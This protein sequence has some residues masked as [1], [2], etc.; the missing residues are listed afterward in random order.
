MSVT[1]LSRLA[2]VCLCSVVA[3]V[4]ALAGPA[5]TPG[6]IPKDSVGALAAR[7]EDAKNTYA[8]DATVVQA[9]LPPS[10]SNPVT[11]TKKFEIDTSA[12]K[13]CAV[14]AAEVPIDLVKPPIR[15]NAEFK[16]DQTVTISGLT[17]SLRESTDEEE[18][19]GVRVAFEL[20]DISL[21]TI[22][23]ADLSAE[24]FGLDRNFTIKLKNLSGY[25]SFSPPKTGQRGFK[26]TSAKFSIGDVAV[27]NDAEILKEFISKTV[28]AAL[29]EASTRSSIEAGL[30]SSLG[31]AAGPAV[32]ALLDLAFKLKLDF[33][34]GDE[35]KSIEFQ[36]TKRNPKCAASPCALYTFTN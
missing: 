23:K 14:N 3:A 19:F 8:F 24:C 13:K 12:G 21:T 15:F 26:F 11:L 9:I 32:A 35:I 33:A 2:A 29:S 4:P 28:D 34:A 36:A 20:S 18:P 10:Y 22:R 17:A 1:S 7:L 25:L 27:S 16:I 6:A 31:A 30:A 5:A